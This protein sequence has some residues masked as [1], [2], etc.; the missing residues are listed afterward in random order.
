M[1]TTETGPTM[2]LLFEWTEEREA[3]MHVGIYSTEEKAKKAAQLDWE[4]TL[5]VRGAEP[6]EIAELEWDT[7]GGEF[8]VGNKRIADGADEDLL[9]SSDE[10]C[11]YDI[12]TLF[13][14]AVGIY[15]Y[16]TRTSTRVEV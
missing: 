5:K 13:L 4:N 2:F 8:L 9:Y 6:H 16:K 12:E 14:D 11:P 10:D 3:K 1:A 15:N 7:L